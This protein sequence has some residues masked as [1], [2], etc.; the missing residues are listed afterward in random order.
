MQVGDFV[1][2]FCKLGHVSGSAARRLGSCASACRAVQSL[3]MKWPK[4]VTYSNVLSTLAL[5]VAVAVAL[6]FIGSMNYSGRDFL[7]DLAMP[8][9]ILFLSAALGLSG[10]LFG[11][12]L[13][14]YLV[15][16]DLHVELLDGAL[17]GWGTADHPV[18]FY[19]I[20]YSNH[21]PWAVAEDVQIKIVGLSRS[22][23]GEPFKQIAV[24]ERYVHP[25]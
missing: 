18:W 24:P 21:R 16:P 3:G 14:Q 19:H 6:A 11:P 2:L 25:R 7:H 12:R 8:L 15:G 13:K 5:A 22:K 10:Y 4:Q 17:T 9:V 1:H 23:A 20:N